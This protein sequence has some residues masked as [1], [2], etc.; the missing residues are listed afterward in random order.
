MTAGLA[1]G[2]TIGDGI[3]ALDAIAARVLPPDIRTSLAGQS[4][5]FAD[6]GSSLQFA[7]VLAIVLIYLML[8]AQFESFRDPVVILVTVPL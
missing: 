7:F 3:A 8:A 4:R 6:A 2:Y 1:P 5:D